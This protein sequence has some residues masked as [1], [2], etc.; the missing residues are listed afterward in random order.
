MDPPDNSSDMNV[1]Q[2]LCYKKKPPCTRAETLALR[3]LWH[4]LYVEDSSEY[5]SF[6]ELNT[7][8]KNLF[9]SYAT[10]HEHAR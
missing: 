3:K 4:V 9:S 2:L 10:M 8:Y 5:R 7:A 6:R 1:R